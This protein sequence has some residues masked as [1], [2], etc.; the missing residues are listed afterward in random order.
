MKNFGWILC[1]LALIGCKDKAADSAANTGCET[2]LDETYPLNDA[3]DM[4]WKSNLEFSFSDE[5]ASASVVVT[6]ASGAEVSGRSIEL[7]GFRH[8]L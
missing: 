4:Y 8:V 3:I 6:D 7:H 2:T 1:G 5:D